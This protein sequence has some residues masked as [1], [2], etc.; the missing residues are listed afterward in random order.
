ME[1]PDSRAPDRLGR[2]AFVR[3]LAA[4]GLAPALG[5]LA[6][7]GTAAR[8]QPGAGGRRGGGGALRLLYWQAPTILNPHIATGAK[9]L[10]GSRVFYEPLAEF[11]TEG[12][13][14]PIL[15][16]DIPS[17]ENGGVA[18][19]G[20][21]VVWT[22]KRHVSWHDGKPF[23]ADD[24]V[25]N[26]EYAADPATAATSLGLYRDLKR[27]ERVDDHRVRVVFAQPAPFW[28]EPF[29]GSGG[30]LIPRHV[31][32][33]YRGAA[34]R[35]AAANL[36]PVGT[37]PYRFA[38]FRPGDTLRA[39][40]N[41][42]YHVAGRPAFDTLE[43][44]GGGDAVSAARAVLQTGEYDFAWNVQ[45]EDALLRRLEEGGKGRVVIVPSS[46]P[47]HIRLNF[48]DPWREVDGERAHPGTRHPLLSDP[49]VRRALALVVDRDAIAREIYGRQGE[50]TANFLNLPTRFRSP[51]T[52][53]EWSVE[54]AGQ[55]LEAAGWR[56]GAD[57]IR[58]KDGRKLK[59]VFQT[60]IN[61]PRQKTQAIVKQA[62]A[63]AGID[64]E[65]KS[66]VASVFFS[67]D[68]GN[69]DTVSHF[70][71]DLQM[72]AVF[73]GRPDP[74][75]FMEQFTS[76]QIASRANKWARSNNTRWRSEEY[77]RLW[78]AAEREL[79]PARRAQLFIRMND[80]VIAE[81]VVIPLV[82]RRETAAV[83]NRLAGVDLT[84]WGSNLWNLHEWR[85][86]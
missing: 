17:V 40:V 2:R 24:V 22:L 57:G 46:A 4:G 80:L 78:R 37:G 23:T 10:A 30:L 34:S 26:W 19:D 49:A 13:L 59:L 66:V 31:F 48:A 7:A 21:W 29:C 73:M 36:K 76:W 67:S 61:A 55:V 47:E 71:A 86:A 43:I 5:A 64:V 54:R 12:R 3:A 27:V 15:A 58:A 33:P 1:S 45:A 39:A 38:D 35:E 18:P 60:S 53:W 42:A 50:A 82:L 77:D 51:N 56:R 28:A 32:A 6:G 16:A 74:Q 72:Y 41:P 83:S 9:D 8:A 68:A 25:F 14:V 69:P 62:A 84:P 70:Y 44:K 79:D 75:R 52:R 11:D 65:I 85:P 20:T 81:G 63:R